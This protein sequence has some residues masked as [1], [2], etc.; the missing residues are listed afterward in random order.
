[1]RST[2]IIA[3][4]VLVS[5]GLLTAPAGALTITLNPA[6]FVDTEA[7]DLGLDIVSS[8]PL[9]VP[10][11]ASD[12]AIDGG[13]TSLTNVVPSTTGF[14]FTFDHSRTGT[15][16]AHA[17][18][19]GELFFTAD[20]AVAYAVSGVYT[21]SDANGRQT[22]QYVA[23]QRVGGG[24]ANYFS[25]QESRATPNESFTVGNE[26][27]DFFN[28]VVGSPTGTLA[29]GDLY[30]LIFYNAIQASPTAGTGTATASGSLFVMLAPVPEPSAALLL[31]AGLAGLAA[32][33]R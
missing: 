13:S 24:G 23:L 26:A 29:A 22:I 19:S 18:T 1:M 15:L 27:G 7:A 28:T 11:S 3:A 25:Y 4:L 30:H 33:R 14:E 17:W 12:Q 16:D 8:N 2:R 20:A 6:S 21:T 32:V 9:A 31:L 5:I 10:Y